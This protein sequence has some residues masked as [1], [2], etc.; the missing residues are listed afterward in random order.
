MIT[1][2][3]PVE[4]LKGG[5]TRSKNFTHFIKNKISLSPMETILSIPSELEYLES[6]MKLVRKKC[7]ENI[8]TT[9]VIRVE[10]MSIICRIY[11]KKSHYGKTL[12]LLMDIN[13]N[14]V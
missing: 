2:S 10:G 6:L 5:S 13:N 3:R 8:I 12:H 1:R 14:L 11:I 7:D 4:S 9:N